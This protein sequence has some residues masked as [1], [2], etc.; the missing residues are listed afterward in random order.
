MLRDEGVKATSFRLRDWHE[1]LEAHSERVL[2]LNLMPMKAVTELDI[3]RM[4]AQTGKDVVLLPVKIKGQTYKTTPMEH[5]RRFYVDIEDVMAAVA[6]PSSLRLIVTGAPVEQYAFEEVR[7]WNELCRIMDWAEEK[8]I[9]TLYICWGAQA[10]LYHHYGIPKYPLPE[11]RF[12]IFEQEV[13]EDDCPLLRGMSPSFPMPNSR[14]TEVR[15]EDFRSS[16]L[17]IVAEGKESG[18]GVAV[19]AA[20]HATYIVGHLEYEPHTLENEYRRD[21]SKGLPIHIPEHYYAEDNPRG[22]ILFQWAEAA[23][24]FY[25]NWLEL[26]LNVER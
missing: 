15:R 11:K 16:D 10:A 14:H 1:E 8:H 12:G 5:M 23:C 20:R 9:H 18:A 6:S 3:A 17:R 25:T 13:L 22:E 19:N 4:M 24:R 26:P 21:L 7:Y 2:L